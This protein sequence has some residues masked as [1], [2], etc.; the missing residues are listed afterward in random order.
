MGYQASIR[1]TPRQ[2]EKWSDDEVNRL[3]CLAK[4]QLRARAI[5]AELGRT[6][7]GVRGKAASVGIAL[8]SDRA[9]APVTLRRVSVEPVQR[10]GPTMDINSSSNDQNLVAAMHA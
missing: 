10:A 5:A 6:E 9:P 8:V 7:A 3:V 1:P 4:M 2:A